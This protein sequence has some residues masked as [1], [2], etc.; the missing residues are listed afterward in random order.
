MH[1]KQ[2]ITQLL[3]TE[4]LLP[5]Y[6]HDSDETSV[7]IL[8][9]LYNAGI[10][11]IEYT[12]R[13]DNALHNF[14]I[15]KKHAEENLPGLHVGA[16][17]IKTKKQARKFIDAGADFIIC[18]IINEEVARVVTDE[19]LLWIPGCMTPT[20]IALAEE[21]DAKVVK[22]FPGNLLGP[23]YIRSIKELFPDLKFIP[24]GGVQPEVTNLKEWFNAG[25]IA[26]GLGSQLIRK[27]LVEENNYK[28]L[29]SITRSTISIIKEIRP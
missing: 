10:R 1:K 11:M 22:V 7:K 19:N 28:A 27:D 9:A 13:G 29:E 26:V 16:G 17:T 2:I 18:P 15:L 6:Y 23:G 12:N 24:T 8:D 25:V 5:L 3:E 4:K 14:K 21:C 20:E